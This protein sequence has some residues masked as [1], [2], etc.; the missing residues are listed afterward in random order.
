[1]GAMRPQSSTRP[2][3]EAVKRSWEVEE[4]LEWGANGGQGSRGGMNDTT[5]RPGYLE[6]GN[7]WRTRTG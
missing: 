7:Y 2:L 6:P 5:E 4:G 1:M 3:H